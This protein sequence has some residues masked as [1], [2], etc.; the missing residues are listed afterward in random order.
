MDN[1]SY[2][3]QDKILESEFSTDT[4][5]IITPESPALNGVH[6]K[7][8]GIDEDRLFERVSAIIDNRK[9]RAGAY[10]NREATLTYWEVGQYINVVVLDNKRAAYGKRILTTLSAKL[11]AKYGSNFSERNIYRMTLFAER[12]SNAKILPPLAAKLSWSH[13]IELLPLESDDV[14]LFYAYDAITRNYG[15][16]ELRRQI[17][18]QNYERGEIANSDLSDETTVPFNVFKDPY[19][20]DMLGLKDNYLEA[21]LE[22]AILTNIEAFLLEFGTGFSFIERQKRMI[23]DSDDVVLDLLLYNRVL[24]RLV[25][26]EL[27]LGR[28]KAA[29]AGQ[30]QLYLKWLDKYERVEGEEAPIGLILCATKSREKIELL[31]LD[32]SGIA[33]SE[34]WTQLPPKAEFEAKI[35]EIMIEAKERLERRKSLPKSEIIKEI[36]YFIEQKDDEYV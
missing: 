6:T 35:R 31:E 7:D 26:I 2:N 9:Y 10:A 27:K 36:D 23:I 21:D 4:L 12:F 28:F 24:K 19:L 14:R 34:Y 22:K 8:G 29:Y 16:K 30:M 3:S 5:M 18:R 15:A 20:L 1:Q 11:V 33:V 13:F 25:A 32:K 17:S